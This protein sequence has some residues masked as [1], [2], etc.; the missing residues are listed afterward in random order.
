MLYFGGDNRGL[1]SLRFP[2]WLRHREP[3]PAG[4]EDGRD[5]SLTIYTGNHYIF[6]LRRTGF[7]PKSRTQNKNTLAG[8]LFWWR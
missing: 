6:I 8:A 1:Q 7:S 4:R 3:P 2:W 5:V